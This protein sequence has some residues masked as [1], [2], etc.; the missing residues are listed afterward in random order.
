MEFEIRSD[1]YKREKYLEKIRGLYHEC[2]K[3]KV[4]SGVRGCGKSSIM[5][6]IAAELIDSGVSKENILYVIYGQRMIFRVKKFNHLTSTKGD[7]FFDS[8]VQNDAFFL[9][10][11]V[12]N[13]AF[14]LDYTVQN[15]ALPLTGRCFCAMIKSYGGN[16]LC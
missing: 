2:E 1:L 10:Y 13:D 15:D 8:A 9:D 16:G 11:T 14:F 3:I 7:R 4:L 5:N 12:Q 6:L